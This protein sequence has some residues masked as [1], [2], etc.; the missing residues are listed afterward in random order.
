M[1]HAAPN[2][3]DDLELEDAKLHMLGWLHERNQAAI[4]ARGF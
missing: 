1:L 4:K 2:A 3:W